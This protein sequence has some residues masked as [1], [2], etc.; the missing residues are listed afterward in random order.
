MH[1][2]LN[3]P[4]I[5]SLMVWTIALINTDVDFSDLNRTIVRKLLDGGA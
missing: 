5:A 1:T 4:S 3:L 2:P